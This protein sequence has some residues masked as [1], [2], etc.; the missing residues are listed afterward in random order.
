ML[1]GGLDGQRWKISVVPDKAAAEKGGKE[2]SDTII[3]AGDKFSSTALDAKGFK[4]VSYRGDFEENE[5]E[6]EAEQVSETE[7]V[8]LWLG[9]IRSDRMSGTLQWKKKDGGTLLFDFTGTK[10]TP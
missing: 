6:F 4:P 2:F 7:G 5:A 10:V 1:G 8:V 9:E 3:F